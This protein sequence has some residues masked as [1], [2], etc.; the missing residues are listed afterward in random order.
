MTITF[1]GT[2][3]WVYGPPA[4][5]MAEL[6]P[7]YK[8]CLHESYQIAPK[9]QCYR[10]NIPEAYST[11]EDRKNP[12]IVFARGQLQNH[13]HQIIISVANP[14]PMGNT[15]EFN[16]IKFFCALYTTERLVP[17]PVEED[18]W[19]YRKVVM[20][21]TH[22]MLSYFPAIPS[23]WVFWRVSPWS[24]KIHTADDGVTTS[25][26]ELK[27]DNEG[28][29]ET[30]IR[31][32]AVAIYG[33]PRAYIEHQSL[34]VLC[35]RLDQG[36]CKVINLGP[37][38][39]SQWG[40]HGSKPV[41]LWRDDTLDPSRETRVSIQLVKASNGAETTFPF[42]SINYREEQEYSSP[43]PLAGHLQNVT[44]NHDDQAISY[45]PK[46]RC[47]SESWSGQCAT[48]FD[49]WVKNEAG[50]SGSILTYRST[51]SQYRVKEDPYI[52]LNFKGEF[53]CVSH[54]CINNVCRVIDVEQ[55]Y[56]HTSGPA[57]NY[58]SAPLY[59]PHPE[60]EPVLIWAT[61]GL[62]DR[63][64]HTLRLGLAPLPSRDDA[65]MSIVKVVYTQVTY[66]R[67]KDR[68]N[69]PAPK[70][71]HAYSGPSGPPYATKLAH[72]DRKIESSGEIFGSILLL[73]VSSVV[74]VSITRFFGSQKH[75]SDDTKRSLSNTPALD[76]G[77]QVSAVIPASPPSRKPNATDHTLPNP[78]Q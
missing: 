64:E 34:G 45:N 47:I 68:S 52:T 72:L 37:I 44:V 77:R 42:K 5:L 60:L 32:G 35:I 78:R 23:K 53:R 74:Y 62:D 54:V 2:D 17:W 75:K 57:V 58:I 40:Q 1:K 3:V 4:G 13:Q 22:P 46:R 21:D 29:V 7:D 66:R 71:Y 6:P 10:I 38:Y 27:S 51:L 31:A 70:P 12:V 16:G 33:A 11:S 18:H 59:S 50:P 69:P 25:W 48:W 55:A 67:E 15:Q 61:T 39:A 65:A 28:S 41:L 76:Q 8:I 30:K 43:R 63:I 14:E 49:P 36:L 19:R 9:S 26:H 73:V 20:H 24:A 56:L